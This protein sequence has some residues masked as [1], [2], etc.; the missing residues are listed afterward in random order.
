MDSGY[1]SNN[2]T[3]CDE[4]VKNSP[5]L[6][7]GQLL[8]FEPPQIENEAHAESNIDRWLQE[9]VDPFE[10]KNRAV[11]ETL[12][13]EPELATSALPLFESQWK[14]ESLVLSPGAVSCTTE[15]TP[16]QTYT[17]SSSSNSTG[18]RKEKA[19]WSE[20]SQPDRGPGEEDEE[21]EEEEPLPKRSKGTKDPEDG[22]AKR[23][24]CCPFHKRHPTIY[25]LNRDPNIGTKE[26]KKWFVCGGQGFPHLRHLM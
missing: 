6:K 22:P 15:G 5:D 23:K 3:T 4:T 12:A 24:F 19:Q 2:Q 21:E 20:T 26:Q 18:K 16:V 25:C 1:S 8:N 9:P 14:L 11:V 13:T 10:V 17:P 7:G